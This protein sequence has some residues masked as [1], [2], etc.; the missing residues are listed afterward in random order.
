MFKMY[1][2]THCIY[3]YYICIWYIYFIKYE[4]LYVTYKLHMLQYILFRKS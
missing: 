1:K 3:V 4:K 2:A